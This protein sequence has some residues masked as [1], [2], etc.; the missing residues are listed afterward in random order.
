MHILIAPDKFKGSLSGKQ[1]AEAIE[2]GFSKVFPNAS[3]RLLPLADGGEGILEAFREIGDAETFESLVNDALGREVGASWLVSRDGSVSTAVIESSQANGLWRI[4]EWER[5]LPR[6]SSFGVGQLI[7]EAS[8]VGVE[9]IFIGIGGSATNDA[10]LGI[11]AALGCRFLDSAGNPVEPVPENFQEIASIDS[12]EMIP[13]SP[14]TVACDVENPL[15]GPHGA[16]RVYGPQKGLLPA[17]T[18]AAEAGLNHFSKITNAHFQTDFTAV[19]GAGAAGGLGYGLMTFCGATLESGFNCIANALQAEAHVSKADLVIT[20]EGSLDSQTL[21]GKTPIGVS[22][23]ARKHGIPVYAF[24][25]RLADEEL[26][27]Q[28]FNGIASITNSPMTLDYAI[29]NASQLLELAAA[30]LAHTLESFRS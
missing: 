2:R 5:N 26:L 21:E 8:S 19:P 23:L 17:D 27:Q 29:A 11:A 25:G 16:T 12:S 20:A 30:R 15:L 6:S 10:G 9:K 13:L 4:P 3:Y 1:A 24:A 28:H 7:R 18:E 14:V 22:R